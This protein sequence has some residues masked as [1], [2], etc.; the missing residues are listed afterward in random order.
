[1]AERG[2]S[3]ASFAG[4]LGVVTLDGLGPPCHDSCSRSESVEAD[5]ITAWGALLC[6]LVAA[7]GS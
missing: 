1:V 4:A 2:G 6:D 5:D 7:A 3:D